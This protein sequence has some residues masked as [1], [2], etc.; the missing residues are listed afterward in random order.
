MFVVRKNGI[1]LLQA[2]VNWMGVEEKGNVYLVSVEVPAGTEEK[3]YDEDDGDLMCVCMSAYAY[4]S[5][6]VYIHMYV[7]LVVV[8][9]MCVHEGDYIVRVYV[10]PPPVQLSPVEETSTQRE[11][12]PG[13][14]ASR[15]VKE[16]GESWEEGGGGWEEGGGCEWEES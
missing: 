6:C 11:W 1:F 16:G 2:T 13:T 3:S 9:G 12:E 8:R 14:L 5:T 7:L 4:V 10:S 15:A